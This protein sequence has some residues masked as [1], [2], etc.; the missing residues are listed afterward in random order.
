MRALI[1]GSTGFLG[2]H[3]CEHLTKLEIPYDTI[4]RGWHAAPDMPHYDL[5]YLAGEV[6]KVED[7]FDSNVKLLYTMLTCSLDWDCVF[8]Y[9]GSS[10][11]YGRMDRPMKEKDLINPTNLYEA[12]KGAGTLLC[13]GVAREFKRPIVIIRPSSVYGKYERPEKFIP[14]VI[15]KIKNQEKLD[16]YP[17]VHDYVHV[18][19]LIRAIFAAVMS[20]EGKYF[21]E[22]YNVSSGTHFAN[23]AIAEMISRIMDGHSNVLTHSE[24]FHEHDTNYWIVDNSKIKALGWSPEYNIMTGL[25]KTV[26]DILGEK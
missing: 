14:T 13:Q 7:M 22:I 4:G 18:D 23:S 16:I 24:K 3:L 15:H 5:V 9:L 26:K 10:S 1:S 21:G 20:V 11:E 8:V 25:A 19:D 6:R 17:G 12:T 2:K